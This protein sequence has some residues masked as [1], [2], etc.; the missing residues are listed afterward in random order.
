MTRMP[1]PSRVPEPITA[2]RRKCS[3]ASRSIVLVLAISSA[4]PAVA[5]VANDLCAPAADPCVVSQVVVATPN[6][7]IDVGNRELQIAGTGAIEVRAGGLT[8]RGRRV[9]TGTSARLRTSGSARSD[10]GAPLVIEADDV[11]LTGEVDVRGSPAGSV[12]ITATGTITLAGR[13]RGRSE[14]A[15]ESA[16]AVTLSAPHVVVAAA[17]EL[18]GGAEDSG[19]DLT[20]SANTVTVSGSVTVSGGEGGTVDVSASQSLVVTAAA[21]IRADATTASNDGGEISL[22]SDAVLEVGGRVSADGRNGV[23]DGGGDGGTIALVGDEHVSLTAAAGRVQALA[24][25]PDGAGGDI[26]ISS[27]FGSIEI[28]GSVNA[29]G[30]ANEGLGGLLEVAADKNFDLHGS[31]AAR[32]AGAGGGEIDVDAGDRVSIHATGVIDASTTRSAAAGGILVKAGTVVNVQ[33]KLFANSAQ[34]IAGTGGSI[35]LDGCEVAIGTAAELRCRGPRGATTI[36]AG[37]PIVVRGSLSSGPADGVNRLRFPAAGPEPDTTGATIAPPATRFADPVLSPC[38]PV[39]ATRT[40]TVT[41][42]ATHTA[43]SPPTSTPTP[44]E[45]VT[46]CPGDCDGNGRVSIAELVRAVN[47]ALQNDTVANCRAADV[48]GDGRVT[49]NELI[50]AVNSALQQCRP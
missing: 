30:D 39:P 9:V 3:T 2:T 36:D 7:V 17:V 41:A 19:G 24:G 15:T 1:S 20:I 47:I 40:P 26:E 31:L 8:L 42:T 21:S 46:A 33:G 16:S 14:S 35:T 29:S 38:I 37:G 22:R 12:D 6:S 25:S 27:L 23:I 18:D 10:P 49:I 28:R 5:T 4:V 44:T 34:S 48:N 43:P 13:L 11:A 45:P 50:Q 32:G